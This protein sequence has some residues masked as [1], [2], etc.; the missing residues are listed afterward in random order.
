MRKSPSRKLPKLHIKSRLESNISGHRSRLHTDKRE[1][2][3]CRKKY[4]EKH[5]KSADHDLNELQAT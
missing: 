5:T 3:L 4:K 1:D 2:C